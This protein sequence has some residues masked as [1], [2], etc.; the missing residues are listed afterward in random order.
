MTNL[1]S[2]YMYYYSL[3]DLQSQTTIPG[4]GSL[5]Q[6]LSYEPYTQPEEKAQG[7]LHWFDKIQAAMRSIELQATLPS[8]EKNFTVIDTDGWSHSF[9]YVDR[10]VYNALIKEK[11]LPQAPTLRSEAEIQEYLKHMNPYV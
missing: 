11:L 7:A 5:I 6:G 8:L 4:S 1:E 2:R 3:I 9:Q 10:E